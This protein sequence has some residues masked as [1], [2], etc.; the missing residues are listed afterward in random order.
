MENIEVGVD[1]PGAITINFTNKEAIQVERDIYGKKI[2]LIPEG[3]GE[4][5]NWSC[6]GTMYQEYMPKKCQQE[7][8]DENKEMEEQN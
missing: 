3:M 5:L 7:I 4:R 6:K 2:V 8:T 1:A